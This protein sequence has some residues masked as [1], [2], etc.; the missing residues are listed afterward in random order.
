MKMLSERRYERRMPDLQSMA[1]ICCI[2]ASSLN[3]RKPWDFLVQSVARAWSKR[4]SWSR[5]AYSSER[6]NQDF[7]GRIKVRKYLRDGNKKCTMLFLIY[8][9]ISYITGLCN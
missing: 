3:V 6:D 2:Y 9:I 7:G 4:N 8:L 5:R 1:V